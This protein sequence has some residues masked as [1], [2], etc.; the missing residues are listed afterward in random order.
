M[1]LVLRRDVFFLDVYRVKEHWTYIRALA[2]QGFLFNQF[3]AKGIIT[4]TV[5]VCHQFCY[6]RVHEE[7][8][9]S[10]FG[11][12]LITMTALPYSIP[13]NGQLLQPANF[14]RVFNGLVSNFQ[15]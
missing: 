3:A 7:F 8:D 4:F 1:I 12:Y 15:L 14:V 5:N 2:T 6:G 13:C 10:N 9:N 11:I